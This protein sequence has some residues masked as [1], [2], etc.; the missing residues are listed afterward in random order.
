MGGGQ[1]AEVAGEGLL[2]RV[3]EVMGLED[4]RLVDV[5]G[6]ADGGDL[7]RGERPGDVDAG[8]PGADAC[9]DLGDLEG[10]EG[11]FQTRA[12]VEPRYWLAGRGRP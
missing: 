4:Q 3:V 9:G 12:G 6:L 1:V 7:L 8:D 5:E 2:A 11:S 10:H